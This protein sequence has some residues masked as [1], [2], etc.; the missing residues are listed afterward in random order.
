[1]GGHIG[2]LDLDV[3]A[4]DGERV[5]RLLRD[6]VADRPRSQAADILGPEAQTN[7]RHVDLTIAHESLL[8]ENGTRGCAGILI[9]PS[10]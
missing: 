1:M 10:F 5:A 7:H 9:T 2:V 6:V 3:A 4:F 8:D